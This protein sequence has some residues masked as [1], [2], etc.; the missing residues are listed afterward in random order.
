[1]TA[2]LDARIRLTRGTLD[3]DVE[4]RAEAGQV[5]GVLGPNG[6]GKTS[7]VLA[8]AGV[9]RV[10][11]GHVRVAAET[12]DEDGRRLAPEA[13][14]VGL[15]LADP[16]LFPHLRAVDTLNDGGA[17]A[18]QVVNAA[19][20]K[21]TGK[22][23]APEVLERA[24]GNLAFTVDPLAASLRKS[25]ADARAVGLLDPVDLAGIYALDPLAA[26]LATAGRPPVR[27]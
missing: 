26:V 19:L 3:L 5:I 13:R 4:L 15:M 22:A 1:M 2:G 18:R 8:L 6:G 27:E 7:T 21:L 14:H 17:E 10:E 24:F 16:L 11:S 23:L 25:A 9:L 12:W 20:E